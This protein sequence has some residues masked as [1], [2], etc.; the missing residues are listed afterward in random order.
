[1]SDNMFSFWYKLG[2]E[3]GGP[4]YMGLYQWLE[5]EAVKSGKKVFFSSE[6]GKLLYELFEEKS[7]KNIKCISF[8]RDGFDGKS[9]E[10]RDRIVQY[11][12]ETGIFDEDV[13]VFDLGWD[14]G[15]QCFFEKL[16]RTAGVETRDEFY[17]FGILN[18]ETAIKNLKGAHYKTYLFDFWNNYELQ[19]LI[20]QVPE[21]CEMFF[22]S[23]TEQDIFEGIKDY[24]N[25]YPETCDAEYDDIQSFESI[26]PLRRLMV[27]PT[28]E[29]AKTIGD[30]KKLAFVTEKE[31]DEN[32]D[33]S[34]FWK[35]GFLTRDDIPHDFR[36]KVA[37]H[38]DMAIPGEASEKDLHLEVGESIRSYDR[39]IRNVEETLISRKKP[40]IDVMFSIVVPVYN[41]KVNQLR[42]CIDS[43]LKQ[44]YRNF[45]LILVEDCSTQKD[46][47]PTLKEYENKEN[48]HIIYR[49]VNGNI[50]A[51]T[52]DGIEAAKGDYIVFMDCDDVMVEHALNEFALKLEEDPELDFIYTDEDKITEEDQIRHMAYFKP[53]WSPDLYM[54]MNYTNHLSTYRASLVKKVGGLRTEFNGSQDYDFTLRFLELTDNKRI[55]HI[56]KILYHWRE[57]RESVAYETGSKSYAIIAAKRAKEDAI[58][59]R[60]LKAHVEYIQENAQYRFVYDT[61]GN[62][63][64]SIVIPSKDH[65]EVLK[66]CIESIYEY[67]AYKNFEIIVVDNGSNK[68]N[69]T[70]ISLYLNNIKAK[71]IYG[72]YPFNFSLMCNK[73]AE[74]A[75]GEYI[76]FLN[77]DIEIFRPEWLERMLGQA[78][79]PHVGAVGAKLYYPGTTCIQHGGV[80][81]R[82]N[83]P[84]HLLFREEDSIGHYFGCNRVDTDCIAVTGAC[85]MV[86]KE[87]F[88]KAG[89]FD[90]NFPIAYND[91]ALCYSLLRLGYYN[92]LRNDV[93]CFHHESLS[94]GTDQE[95]ETK[96]LR[97]NREYNSLVEKFPEYENSDPFLNPALAIY[98]IELELRD[99]YEK[100]SEI[101]IEG[102]VAGGAADIDVV[103]VSHLVLIKGWSFIPGRDDNEELERFLLL[104]DPFGRVLKS[105][106]C[107]WDRGDV[108]KNYP[109]EPGALMSGIICLI[110]KEDLRTDV[111]PYHIGVLTID[112]NGQK[113]VSWCGKFTPAI[114][115]PFPKKQYSKHYYKTDKADDSD[116]NTVVNSE[117]INTI[118]SIESITED[119]YGICIEGFAF[120]D[121]FNHFDYE[122][123]IE[124]GNT[125]YGVQKIERPDVAMYYPE[126]NYLYYT[127]FRCVILKNT[128]KGNGEIIIRLKKK[129][130]EKEKDVCIYTGRFID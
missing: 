36:K 26:E 55:G 71:Y 27:F 37:D 85:L 57:R 68:D 74:N 95:D 94:R 84:G 106:I 129:H 112:K 35:R 9:D 39:W 50:S 64:V 110:R 116:N 100:L 51:A 47:V 124:I 66:Q 8:S 88:E 54:S 123:F 122:T 65:P 70:E 67:T 69:S 25:T 89:R 30:Y 24:V 16:K 103:E 80:V 113:I 79:Q 60:G 130:F 61:V 23:N 4:I 98:G 75:K 43:V 87:K 77:D 102:A 128:L 33:V 58:R 48:I 45:E 14:G 117:S 3:V 97:L 7:Y 126:K 118:W 29:E 82:E 125:V 91:V 41:V 19:G 15:F 21:I 83:G 31:F 108:K 20:K 62:P 42:D 17:Y 127:G 73:G 81:S 1:M 6:T 56:P 12:K 40:A 22:A 78:M 109:D 44:T 34:I 49:T 53:D 114:R 86:S 52:N 92:V 111:I 5:K 99:K 107:R 18:S 120:A 46:V 96:L 13:V 93:V 115:E 101:R 32:R 105:G 28:N 38:Y 90:E 119:E 2:K 104:E 72:E 121:V 76:L 63:L 10:E 11:F 59:R